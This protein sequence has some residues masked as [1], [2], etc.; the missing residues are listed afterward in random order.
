MAIDGDI[1]T[2]WS[3]GDHADPV[4]AVLRLTPE[5][6]VD[7]LVL[8][9]IPPGPG[10]RAIA[11][12]SVVADGDE[13]LVDLGAASTDG[14]GQIVAFDRPVVGPIDIVITAVTA[15]EVLS[16]MGL[17]GVGFAEIG[18]G[19]GPTVEFMRPPIDAL[20]QLPVGHGPLDVV[21][22]RER[23]EATSFWRGDPEPLLRRL[24]PLVEPESFAVAATVR[25]DQR[26]TDAALVGLLGDRGCRRQSS[27]PRNRPSW[28]CGSRR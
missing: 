22:T 2:A 17:G 3:V 23:V 21:F 5:S 13:R 24:L 9:Q 8:H 10:G 1:S 12:I 4:G 19:L 25:L 27:T 14:S 6:A 26:A 7:E 16:V 28:S 15:S 20:E 11:Q 18:S